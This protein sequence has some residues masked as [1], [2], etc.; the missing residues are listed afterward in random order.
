MSMIALTSAFWAIALAPKVEVTVDC[1]EG[2]VVTGERKFR[3]TVT[4]TNPDDNVNQ[5]EF[6]VGADLRDSDTSTP[7]EF[8]IDS[9][10]EEEGPLKLRFKAFTAE[11]QSAEKSITVRIDNGLSKGAGF[12][13]EQGTVSYSDGKYREAIVSGRIALKIEEKSVPARVLLARANFALGIFDTA[14]KFAEDALAIDP[15]NVAA[16]EVLSGVNLRRAF[17]TVSRDGDRAGTLASIRSAFKQAVEARKRVLDATLDQIGAPTD[18]NL[19]AYADAAIRAQ[20]YSLVINSVA[21]AFDRDNSR[22]DLANRLAYSYVRTGRYADALKVLGTLKR[23][24]KLDAYSFATAAVANAQLGETTNSDEAIKEAL[25]S[26][27]SDLGVLTAQAFIALKYNRTNVLANLSNRLVNDRAQR[28]ETWYYVAAVNNRLRRFQEGRRGF[29]RSVLAEPTNVDAYIE[30][31]NESMA[32]VTSSKLEQKELDYLYDTARAFY[33]TALVARPESA[34]ALS[35]VLTVL[36]YQN[37]PA[38][39]VAYGEAA[40]KASPE[41]AIAHYAAAAAY[42]EQAS[43]LSKQAGGRISADVS[44]FNGLAAAANRKA[45]TLDTKFLEGRTIPKVADVLKYLTE[46]GRSPVLSAPSR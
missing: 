14:Q 40:I 13:I 41:S 34:E 3:V 12:H 7:Y 25:L 11:G 33:D 28:T 37:K 4:N 24:G 38:E 5:V 39:A 8:R 1:P 44:K 45:G 46:A 43:F 10:A 22:T 26:N 18:I 6:Y 17:N 16:S 9:L 27:E 30:R 31:G 32:V 19:V 15:V 20:R 35:G 29:E 2:Q 36:L 23:Y 42:A 21:P